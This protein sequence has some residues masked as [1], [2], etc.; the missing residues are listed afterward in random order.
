MFTSK[1]STS[2]SKRK[3]VPA[4]GAKNPLNL[5]HS[6]DSKTDF[7]RTSYNQD[8]GSKA[9]KKKSSWSAGSSKYD[10]IPPIGRGHA[11][12]KDD[13]SEWGATSS[14]S[15]S[16]LTDSSL[17]ESITSLPHTSSK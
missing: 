14:K 17:F 16:S 3:S 2:K 13:K 15:E 1:N 11:R 8:F 6:L 9:G 4:R 12:F 10:V 5:N 7:Y